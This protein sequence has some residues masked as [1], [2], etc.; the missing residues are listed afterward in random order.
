MCIRDSLIPTPEHAPIA[1]K[2]LEG[3][4]IFV[5]E[6]KAKRYLC[7]DA[8]ILARALGF[9]EKPIGEHRCSYCGEN[10]RTLDDEIAEHA[11]K[12]GKTVEQLVQETV[13]R[14]NS[15]PLP[16]NATYDEHFA[17]GQAFYLN[18]FETLKRDY[19]F[20]DDESAR[21]WMFDRYPEVREDVEILVSLL[22]CERVT[23]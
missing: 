20:A 9:Y 17:A 18:N 3:Y 7:E 14:M 2:R 1:Q 8:P 15:T 6:E 4:C 12:V 13:A 5:T 10:L 19:G 23:L 11:A 22:P 21:Q 16:A